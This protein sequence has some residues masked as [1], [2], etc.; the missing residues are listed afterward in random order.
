MAITQKDF[1]KAVKG[2]MGVRMRIAKNLKVTAAA[3]TY[4]LERNPKMLKLV[5]RESL[6]AV[7][8]AENELY[9][10]VDYD[11]DDS[12]PAAARVRQSSAQFI[13][14]RKAKWSEKQEIEHTGLKSININIPKEVK[15]LLDEK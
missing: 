8:V 10:L 13:L 7:T 2:T 4:Y 15:E 9:N 6:N 3:I 5:E 11:D 12:S 1:T 14:A